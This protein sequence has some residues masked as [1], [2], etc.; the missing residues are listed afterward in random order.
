MLGVPYDCVICNDT[1]FVHPIN[2]ET[3]KVDYSRVVACSCRKSLYDMGRK[4]KLIRLAT[5]PPDYQDKNFYNFDTYGDRGLVEAKAGV[6][7]LASGSDE[8][9]SVTLIGLSDRGKTHLALAACNKWLES[10][11]SLRYAKTALML[12]ELRSTYNQAEDTHQAKFEFFC[13]VGLLIIDDLGTEK[14]TEWGAQE[15]QTIIDYRY[16]YQLPMLITTNRPMTDLFNQNDHPRDSWRNYA[17]MRI[18]SRLQRESW[19]RV[20]VISTEQ[21]VLKNL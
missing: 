12:D 16:D 18:G 9:K 17:N 2:P 19:C 1:G 14:I 6:L 20:Y 4:D 15:L 7:A 8:I 13:K 21:H 3:K 10:G 11:K 5:L